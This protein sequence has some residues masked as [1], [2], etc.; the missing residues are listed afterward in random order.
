MSAFSV[1]KPG[2]RVATALQHGRSWATV[3]LAHW[4]IAPISGPFIASWPRS[5]STWLRTMLTHLLLEDYDSNPAV[6][7]RLIPG[8]TLRH[9]FRSKGINRL[10]LRSTH[11]LYGGYIR[12]AVYLLRDMRGA[13]PSLFRYTTTRVGKRLDPSEWV[14]LYQAGLYG[15][16]WD[17]HVMS[18]LGTASTVL[19]DR[20]LVV[21]Y[22]DMR[23]NPG[24]VLRDVAQFLGIRTGREREA[25]AVSLSAPDVMRR[26]ESRMLGPLRDPN[27]SFYRG[28]NVNEWDSLFSA[29]D[30]SALLASAEDALCLTGYR[31][32]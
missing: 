1:I 23:S 7:N 9:I 19:G 16:R 27:A 15:P 31:R 28:G 13:V 26:W 10:R 6:F 3:P 20:M 29:R 30:R 22:E 25:R 14:K 17:Q 21:R 18:W 11:G 8:T 4:L 32:G 24:S 12:Q 2:V 5:G